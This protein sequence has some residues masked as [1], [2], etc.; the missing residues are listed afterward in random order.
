MAKRK[1]ESQTDSL[2]PDHGKSGIEPIPLRAGGVQQVV[3]KF[4]TRVITLV[5]TSS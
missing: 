5:Q 2:T 4:S 3:E 1:A